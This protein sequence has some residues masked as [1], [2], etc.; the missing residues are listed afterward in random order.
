MYPCLTKSQNYAPTLDY[1]DGATEEIYEEIE[2]TIKKTQK[3][4]RSPCHSGRL[5]SQYRPCTYNQWTGTVGYF[6]WE[7]PMTQE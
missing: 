1:D 7:T 5:E 3:K 2:N 6:G 4:E